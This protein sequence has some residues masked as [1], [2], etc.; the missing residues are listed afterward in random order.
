MEYFSQH[1][2]RSANE[3]RNYRVVGWVCTGSAILI[4][5]WVFV[6]EAGNMHFYIE[7]KW[8]TVA[9]SAFF[10]LATISGALLVVNDCKRRQ[11][12]YGELGAWLKKWDAE[13]DSLRTWASVLKVA[14][15][16]E[17]ALMVELLEW[18]SLIRNVKLPRK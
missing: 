2:I 1:A 10:Q 15:R 6:S 14:T 17:R 11:R 5:A 18:K 3:A 9:V 4:A 12:R 8:L 16:V 13:L 7:K